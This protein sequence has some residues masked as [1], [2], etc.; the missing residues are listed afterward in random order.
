MGPT[1]GCPLKNNDWQTQ[2]IAGAANV[3]IFFFCRKD[4]LFQC[5]ALEA[6]IGH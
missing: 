6:R 1:L 2:W 5:I 3:L 4:D